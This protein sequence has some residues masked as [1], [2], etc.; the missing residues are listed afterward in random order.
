M[1][2]MP[3]DFIDQFVLPLWN[4]RDIE[5]IDTFV[6]PVAD[7]QTTF[8]TGSGPEPLKQKVLHTFNAFSNFEM[9]IKEVIHHENQ[10]IYKWNCN[11]LHTGP[12]LSI[13]PSGKKICFSGIAAGEIQDGLIIKYQSY[14]NMPREFMTGTISFSPEKVPFTTITHK[15]QLIATLKEVTGKRLTLREVECLSLWLKGFS[16]KET[17]KILGGL[18]SRTVQTFRENIKRKLNVDTYKQLFSLTQKTHL[19]PLF[20]SEVP[21]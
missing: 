12:F 20:L 14:S 9:H 19:L 15:Q 3:K 4:K 21:A 1:R 13:R 18:S 10:L 5:V 6:S 16:I 8:V 11:A 7:I 2:I 17:A